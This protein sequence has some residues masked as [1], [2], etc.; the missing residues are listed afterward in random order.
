MPR[1]CATSII[2]TSVIVIL[3]SGTMF[4]LEVLFDIYTVYL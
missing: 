4:I 1:A 2:K 3:F